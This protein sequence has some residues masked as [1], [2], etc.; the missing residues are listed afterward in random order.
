L[1]CPFSTRA[2][3]RTTADL[4]VS[5]FALPVAAAVVVHPPLDLHVDRESIS[6]V[7]RLLSIV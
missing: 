3:T 1:T 4:V 7:E 2:T 6:S 5:E